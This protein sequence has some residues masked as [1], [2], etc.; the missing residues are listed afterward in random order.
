MHSEL[1]R[2]AHH[3]F[4]LVLRGTQTFWPT[5]ARAMGLQGCGYIIAESPRSWSTTRPGMRNACLSSRI[6]FAYGWVNFPVGLAMLTG[7]TVRSAPVTY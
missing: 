5:A 1:H 3:N 4:L 6:A 7:L 2:T